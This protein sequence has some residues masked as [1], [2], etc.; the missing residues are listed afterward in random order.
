MITIFNR[1]EVYVGSSMGEASN[2]RRILA[3][4]NIKYT[5]RVVDRNSSNVVGAQR[6]R[7]STFGQK[8]NMSKTYYI[9]VHKKDYN[10]AMRF[11][12]IN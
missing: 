2:I 3:S 10:D 6:G 12:G 9:Y 4:S 5:Y 7:T 1:E 8:M 11:I